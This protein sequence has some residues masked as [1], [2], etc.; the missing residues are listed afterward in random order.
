[1][2]FNGIFI[3]YPESNINNFTTQLRNIKQILYLKFIKSPYEKN[4]PN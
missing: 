1:M 2:Y 3:K 4:Y